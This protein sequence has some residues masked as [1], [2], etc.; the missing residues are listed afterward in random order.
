MLFFVGCV[1]L[2]GL[3]I[4]CI[5]NWLVKTLKNF[6]GLG[7]NVVCSGKSCRKPSKSALRASLS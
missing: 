5:V 4:V 6:S 3:S 2:E 1:L 7:A